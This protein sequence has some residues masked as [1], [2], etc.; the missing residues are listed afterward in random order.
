MWDCMGYNKFHKLSFV[1]KVFFL[2]PGKESEFKT[3]PAILFPPT[4]HQ[5]LHVDLHSVPHHDILTGRKSQ[6]TSTIF[7]NTCDSRNITL[8]TTATLRKLTKTTP[9]HN[10]STW[11]PPPPPP[12]TE[13]EH[14][15]PF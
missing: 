9:F 6:L 8:T 1:L 2:S 11:N 10:K 7:L 15:T 14:S 3:S 4:K 5:F 13:N 12:L